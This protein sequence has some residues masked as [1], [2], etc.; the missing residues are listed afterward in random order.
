MRRERRNDGPGQL[1]AGCVSAR[2]GNVR[3][4]LSRSTCACTDAAKLDGGG[5]S[6]RTSARSAAAAPAEKKDATLV[7]CE[8]IPCRGRGV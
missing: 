5:K 8:A 2:G 3:Y 1:S 6:A 4:A 7:L